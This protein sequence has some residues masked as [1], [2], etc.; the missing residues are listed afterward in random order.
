MFFGRLY[1]IIIP[2]EAGGDPHR[3]TAGCDMDFDLN[4]NTDMDLGVAGVGRDMGMNIEVDMFYTA[5][6]SSPLGEL[7]LVFLG[8]ALTGVWFSDED[9]VPFVVDGPVTDEAPYVYEKTVKW[10]D[11]YFSGRNPGKLPAVSAIG[12]V[13]SE[14]V[15]KIVQKIPYGCTMTYG[16]IAGKMSENGQNVSPRAVGG[17]VSRN[18][19]KILI[20]CHRVIGAEE[21]VTGYAAGIERKRKLLDLEKTNS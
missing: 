15:W 20:P 4:M 13:F 18:P 10:L 11:T 1:D 12:S 17:A 3:R 2:E 14:N 8:E 9:K 19:I 5:K 16:E 21:A 7:I 6:Y